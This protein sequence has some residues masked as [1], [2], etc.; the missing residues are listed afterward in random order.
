MRKK[1][2]IW[3]QALLGTECHKHLLRPMKHFTV[4]VLRV[5]SC[6]IFKHSKEKT[7]CAQHN[8]NG[9]NTVAERTYNYLEV[10]GSNPAGCW[11]F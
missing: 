9:C 3:S 5:S 8:A 11:Y 4:K 2:L 6:K 7:F 1:T 10:V